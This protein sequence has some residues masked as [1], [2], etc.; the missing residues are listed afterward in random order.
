MIDCINLRHSNHENP[1]VPDG[2]SKK[3]MKTMLVFRVTRRNGDESIPQAT[4][5]IASQ[6]ISD[7]MKGKRS[8]DDLTRKEII[9]IDLVY[10]FKARLVVKGCSAIFGIHYEKTF[11][12]TI[13]FRSL[14]ILL[15]VQAVGGWYKSNIDIGNAYINAFINPN[16]IVLITLPTFLT[17][18]RLVACRLP[19]TR[20]YCGMN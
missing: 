6:A 13:H 18:G 12:P 15:H 1:T 20:A 14:L 17:G 9:C 2:T 4:Y 19:R 8:I 10:K 16:K 5:S 11:S 3:A 7:L